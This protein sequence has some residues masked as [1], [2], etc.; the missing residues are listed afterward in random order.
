M[1]GLLE[2]TGGDFPPHTYFLNPDGKMFA[3]IRVNDNALIEFKK[4]LAFY[5]SGRQFKKVTHDTFTDNYSD[6][7]RKNVKV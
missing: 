6:N 5:K 2:T 3:Y 7:F 1:E 4:P